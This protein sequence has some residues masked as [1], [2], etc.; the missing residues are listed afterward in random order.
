MTQHFLKLNPNKT[1]VILFTPDGPENINGLVH[2]DIEC[3]GFNNCV[4]LLG[5]DLDESLSFESYV[6]ELASRCYFQIRN[7]E[8]I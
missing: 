4:T 8:K 2:P 5:V 3:L 1:E 6:N 7:I